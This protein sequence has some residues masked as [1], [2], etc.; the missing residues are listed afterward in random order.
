MKNNGFILESGVLNKRSNVYGGLGY[1]KETTVYGSGIRNKGFESSSNSSTYGIGPSLICP[2]DNDGG[3]LSKFTADDTVNGNGNL[4]YK[5]GLLTVDEMVL[6]GMPTQSV[7]INNNY[8]ET[9]I[10]TSYLRSNANDIYWTLSPVNFIGIGSFAWHVDGDGRLCVGRVGGSL[11]LRP[12]ISL[13]SA[14][15]ISGG[16]GTA[17]SPFIVN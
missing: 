17:S 11:S 2:K 5:I 4:D 10:L 7:Y 1:R 6:A 8:D 16:T 3:K 15:T 13:K 12:V 14:T 9:L